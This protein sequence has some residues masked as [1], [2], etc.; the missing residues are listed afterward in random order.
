MDRSS[1]KPSFR[2]LNP[3]LPSW[4][5]PSNFHAFSR[6]KIMLDKTFDSAAAEAKYRDAWESSGAFAAEPCL[7]RKSP[8][9]S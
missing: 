7:V 1:P 4:C 8:T 3:S 2:C 5:R 9:R 6:L